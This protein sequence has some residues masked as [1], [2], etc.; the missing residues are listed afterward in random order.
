V[1]VEDTTL[2]PFQIDHIRRMKAGLPAAPTTEEDTMDE[3]LGALNTVADADAVDAEDA[4][5]AEVGALSVYKDP[6]VQTAVTARNKLN[7]EY[8]KYYDDLTA[9]IMA[10]R[11]GPT[12]SERM[13][14]LSAALAQ[15]TT[16][17]GFGGVLENITPVLAAQQ[18]AQREGITKR[19]DALSALQAAQLAQR[20]GLAN[21]DVSTAT[22]MAKLEA[23]ANKPVRGVPVGDTLRNPYTN[24]QIGPEFNRVPKPEYYKAL[25]AAPTPENL[26]AAVAYYPTFEV[27]LKAAYERGLRNKGR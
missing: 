5:D 15:P 19:Q 14:Q 13:F 25:E 18:K 9:K 6:N 4:A 24:A 1:I 7:A 10:Q 17:R 8:K 12:F 23:M 16:R 20:V 11:T 27:D 3:E 2:T 21:Q 26:Q 22:A